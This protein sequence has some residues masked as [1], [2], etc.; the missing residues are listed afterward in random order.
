MTE[1]PS[2]PNSQ[3]SGAVGAN[4]KGRARFNIPCRVVSAD[5]DLPATVTDLSPGGAGIVAGDDMRALADRRTGQVCIDGLGTFDVLFRWKD[6]GRLGVAVKSEETEQPRIQ[7][8][9]EETT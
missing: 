2:Q 5:I 8:L 1:V 9:I 4:D 3:L 7:P 6:D